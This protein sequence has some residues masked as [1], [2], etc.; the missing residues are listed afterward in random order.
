MDALR[1]P[2]LA[3][4]ALALLVS[5]SAA[6]P[7]PP[8]TPGD[9]AGSWQ[10]NEDLSQDARPPGAPG[11]FGRRGGGPPPGGGGPRGGGGGR[12][13]APPGGG[14]PGGGPGRPPLPPDQI[15][16]MAGGTKSL[17]IEAEGPQLALTWGEDHHLLLFT[18]GRKI[19]KEQE[20]GGEIVQRTRWREEH[21]EI[22][23]T[24]GGA[25]VS[26]LW[27]LTNDHKRIFATVEM[28]M[29]GG[30]GKR[31]FRRVWDRVEG[32]QGET[33]PG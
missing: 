27:V 30:R 6:A 13:G 8:Q 4:A 25:K 31:T 15:V 20:E 24:A 2:G 14:P 28:D 17:H 32:A 12:S 23:T 10:L 9:L 5:L 22:E 21:L 11:G 7:Q 18:D 3:L 19:R 1:R 29:P 26:E 16:A 33:S